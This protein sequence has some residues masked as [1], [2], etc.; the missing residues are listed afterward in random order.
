VV[1]NVVTGKPGPGPKYAASTRAHS[2]TVLRM[3]YDFC[4]MRRSVISLA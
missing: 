3:F 4:A 2:E 1:S